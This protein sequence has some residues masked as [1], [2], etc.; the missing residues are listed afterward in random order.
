MTVGASA[1]VSNINATLVAGGRI[2]GTLTDKA[3]KPLPNTAV[4]AYSRDGSLITRIGTADAGG[5]F[6]ITGLS[7][8]KYV[9]TARSGADGLKIYSGNVLTEA[10]ATP[11]AVTVGKTTDMGALSFGTSP[12]A[13]TAAPVPTVTG[14]TVS[15]QKLTA[16]PGM[17]GP[18]PVVLAYQWKRSGVNI[19]GVTAATECPDLR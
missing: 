3:G 10:S 12:L 14:T 13:L 6:S 4:Q 1:S 15:G 18:A 16:V 9:V 7:T 11:V 19:S 8:G 5:R 17:W 2:T